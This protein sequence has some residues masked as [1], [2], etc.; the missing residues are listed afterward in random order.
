ML[1]HIVLNMLEQRR[2]H[3]GWN[4]LNYQNFSRFL[5]SCILL[6]MVFYK[7]LICLMWKYH[8]IELNTCSTQEPS[9]IMD[10]AKQGLLL[11]HRAFISCCMVKNTFFF[12]LL[13]YIGQGFRYQQCGQK[14]TSR[15]WG[16]LISFKS[17]V[18]TKM[19]RTS[20][21]REGCKRKQLEEKAEGHMEHYS[22][23]QN[24]WIWSTLY[25]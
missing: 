7:Q 20:C 25:S 24:Y 21:E 17:R 19:R 22:S 15:N 16:L 23:C 13:P 12:F 9:V 8:E 1:A 2:D 10:S 18:W 11:G 3:L 6:L 14:F 4:N 5:I